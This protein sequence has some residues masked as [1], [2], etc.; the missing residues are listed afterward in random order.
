MKIA[1]IVPFFNE[2][3][4]LIFFI[5]E[6]EKFLETKKKL[7][8]LLYFYFINDGSTD[9]SVEK[10]HKNIKKLKFQIINK[11]NS[12]HGDSC[13]FG[14]NLIIKKYNKFDYLLQIDS[15]NQCNPKYIT[16]FYNLAKIK[17]LDFIFGYRKT[18]EDGFFRILISRLLSITF[19]IKKFIFIKDLNTPYRLMKITK[20]K[21]IINIINNQKKYNNI[22]LFNCVLSYEIEKNYNIFWTNISFRNRKFGRSKFKTLEMLKMYLN[23]IIKI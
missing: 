14:Y 9:Q 20:L 16:S 8:N 19:F 2:K 15:D 4:N 18:R 7:R 5:N 22:K 6:W 1:I 10:I 3:D 23:L 21:E 12:G 11:K 13:K 17:K